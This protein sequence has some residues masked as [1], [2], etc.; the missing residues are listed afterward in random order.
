MVGNNC[1]NKIQNRDKQPCQCYIPFQHCSFLYI[2]LGS[3]QAILGGVTPQK[4]VLG[5]YDIFTLIKSS[6][7]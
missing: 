7:I 6:V 3:L 1:W 5:S 4:T 2:I